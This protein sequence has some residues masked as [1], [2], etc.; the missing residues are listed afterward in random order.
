MRYDIAVH[1]ALLVPANST[2]AD[3]CD[4]H[5]LA[6]DYSDAADISRNGTAGD[7]EKLGARDRRLRLHFIFV[8][9]DCETT[10]LI[11]AELREKLTFE[12]KAE[13]RDKHARSLTCAWA[14]EEELVEVRPQKCPLLLHYRLR[15]LPSSVRRRQARPLHHP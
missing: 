6:T 11:T 1:I 15:P 7:I 2:D 8:K 13:R 3:G 10:S 4:G 14:V 12:L 5:S 9:P